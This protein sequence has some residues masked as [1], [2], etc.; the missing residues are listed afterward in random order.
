MIKKISLSI[1]FIFIIAFILWTYKLQIFLW[2]LPTLFEFTRP[3]AE[4]REVIWPD[5]PA[6]RDPTLADKPNIIL[7][8]ADDLGFNDISLYNGGAGDGN[9]MTP[10]MDRIGLEG[11]KF[12]NGYAPSASCSPSRASI[13]TGRYSTRFGFEFTPAY[14]SIITISK[15]G[16]EDNDTGLPIIFDDDA[17]MTDLDGDGNIGYPG[18]PSSEITIAEILKNEGYY[19]ALVGKWHLGTAP[20]YD[21]TDQGFDDSLQLMG[22]L[23]LPRDHPDVVNVKT[24]ELIDEMVWASTQYSVRKDKSEVFEPRGY[25]TDYYTDEAIKV[26]EKNKN[27]P[28]FLFLS[29]F[30]PHNPLQAL[31]DDYDHFSHINGKESEELKVYSAMLKALDRSVGRI[32]ETLEKNNLSENTLIIL[33][34]DNGGANYIH[35]SDIN[36]PYR[37]WKLTHFEGGLHVPFLMKWPD[38]ITGG[39]EFNYPIHGNDIFPTIAAAAGTKL[40]TDRVIDGVNLLPFILDSNKEAPH[41]T[42]F[43]LQ[44]RLQTVLHKNWKLITDQRLNK[45]WLF[46]IESDPY[47]RINLAN[48]MNLKVKELKALLNNHKEAQPPTLYENS[49]SV[50]VMVDKHAGEA[51]EQ[52]DEFTYWDN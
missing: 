46:N 14:K 5:G 51:F 15:W 35:L 1:F 20:S 45:N 21:P 33:T 29:H 32:Q 41:E 3:V 23:Y 34:S 27:R 42:L 36:K 6:E 24:G 17:E 43:W 37:G 4:N 48:E 8:L 52:G 31:K 2:S 13:M 19:S 30:A 12:N 9:L 25:I 44:G 10:N 47:E 18:M 11:I 40:P 39:K 26:I 28:F 49:W 22:G 16:E 7:I 38:K 50:P